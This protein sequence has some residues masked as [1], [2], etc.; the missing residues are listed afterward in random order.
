MSGLMGMLAGASRALDAQRFGLDVVGQNLANVNTAGYSKRVADFAAVPA[1]DRWSAGGGVEIAGARSMRDRILDRRFRDETSGE[2]REYAIAEQLGMAEVALGQSGASLDRSLN[3]F[4]DAFASLADTPTSATARQQVI[5]QGQTLSTAFRDMAGRMLDAQRD[6]D[7]Q[8]RAGVE[9]VNGLAD[10]IASLNAALTGTSPASPE[11]LHLRDEVNRTLEQMSQWVN[12]QAIEREGGGFDVALSNGSALVVGDKAYDLGISDT[13][14][15]GFADITAAGAVATASITGGRLGGLVKVRD[16]NLA[17]YVTRL[18]E[19]AFA[20]ATEVN[21]L[22]QAGF[23]LSGAAG[24][25][26]F[27]PMGAAGAASAIGMNAALIAA[28]GESLVVASGSA[29]AAGD[30]SVARQLA[31]LREQK[32]LAGGTATASEGWARLVYRVGSDRQAAVNSHQTRG[33][34]SR[35]LRNLQDSVSGVSI[36]EEAA[37]LVRFQR[38]YEANARF[39]STVD[40]TLETLLNMV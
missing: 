36:D 7:F 37:D 14:P 39:F 23:D 34:I 19:M 27:Q 6:A 28:G 29:T 4:F 5:L 40:T 1:Y 21:A 30:N 24:L 12:V 17:E 20:V 9:Q 15:S 35:Q 31:A 26:F 13:P 25:A 10:R 33:E 11:G 22:H 38:A 3:D 2:R 8:V 32:M 16:E 18:D